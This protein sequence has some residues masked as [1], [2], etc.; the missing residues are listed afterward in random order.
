M[1]LQWWELKGVGMEGMADRGRFHVGLLQL[2]LGR[3]PPACHSHRDTMPQPHGGGGAACA[4]A[5]G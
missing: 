1:V 3:A 2:L 4:E 5:C